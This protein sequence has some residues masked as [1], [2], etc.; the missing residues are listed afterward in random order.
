MKA[1]DSGNI[2]HQQEFLTTEAGEQ[3]YRMY[4]A[5]AGGFS[6]AFYAPYNDKGQRITQ[7]FYGFDL[8][9]TPNYDGNRGQ[10]LLDSMMF[11][12]LDG[13]LTLGQQHRAE[14]EQSLLLMYDSMHTMSE[15]QNVAD[16]NAYRAKQAE[17]ALQQELKR[18]QWR[19]QRQKRELEHYVLDSMSFDDY[20]QQQAQLLDAMTPDDGEPK[21]TSSFLD[22][23][24]HRLFGG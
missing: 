16:F 19:E 21:P 3:A 7:G 2:T 23:I 20:L 11:D 5:N 8:V 1:D 15:L 14:L 24:N 18:K 10:G 17:Q 4:K 22:K 12:S 13:G 9:F 6:S